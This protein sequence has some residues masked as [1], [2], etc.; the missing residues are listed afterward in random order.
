M[1]LVRV[2]LPHFHA[3]PLLSSKMDD[4]VHLTRICELITAGK[5]LEEDGFRETVGLAIL[6]NPSGKRKY[7]GDEILNSLRSGEGIVYATGNSGSA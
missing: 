6:M 5:H 7:S 3:Y 1:D 2:V 4:V